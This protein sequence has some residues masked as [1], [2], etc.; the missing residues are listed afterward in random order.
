MPLTQFLNETAS[1]IYCRKAKKNSL[2]LCALDAISKVS[3]LV[4]VLI[5]FPNRSCENKHGN[6]NASR[7][8]FQN[9]GKEFSQFV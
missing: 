5:S 9:N 3:T 7:T 4:N 6:S 8:Y 2:K 1:P